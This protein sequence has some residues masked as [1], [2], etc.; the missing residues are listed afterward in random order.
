MQGTK[1]QFDNFNPK[2]LLPQSL[3]YWNYPG[4]L[5]TPPL[6]ET[7]NWIVLKETISVSEKQVRATMP[8]HDCPPQRDNGNGQTFIELIVSSSGIVR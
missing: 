6:N 1:A 4:S 8:F 3:D 5:T 2:C 7:V